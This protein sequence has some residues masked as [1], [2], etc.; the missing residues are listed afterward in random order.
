MLPFFYFSRMI[1]LSVFIEPIEKLNFNALIFSNETIKIIQKEF[2]TK[3]LNIRLLTSINGF[4]LTRGGLMAHKNGSA[5]LSIDQK[6]MQT[7]HL[8]PHQPFTIEI[9]LD[10][11]KYGL[12]VPLEFEEV[13]Q[14]E[15][16]LNHRFS[17][18][19]IGKQRAII[20]KISQLKNQDL[21]IERSLLYLKNLMQCEV[22]KEDFKVIYDSKD[23]TI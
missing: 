19:S 1:E 14:Q 3:T 10:T 16:I 15:P 5:Y 23:N 2:Q 21:R 11:S 17:Q 7:F 12:D 4:F 13:L 6:T 22:G 20:Y 18:M 9:E 8:K